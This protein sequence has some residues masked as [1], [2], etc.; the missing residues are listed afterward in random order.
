MEPEKIETYILKLKDYSH[1][2]IE[3]V[4]KV[5]ST[6]EPMSYEQFQFLFQQGVVERMVKLKKPRTLWVDEEG[7]IHFL[8]HWRKWYQQVGKFK[9]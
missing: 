3:N 7:G 1:E 2:Q 5:R 9:E 4:R 6:F 8:N